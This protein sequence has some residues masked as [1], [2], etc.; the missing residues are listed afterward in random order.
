MYTT[1]DSLYDRCLEQTPEQLFI[2]SL[3]KEFELS[4]AE[5]KGV[6]ELAKSCL[7][8][9]VPQTIGKVK[10]LCA[11]RTAKHG[12]RLGEQD[13]IMVELTCLLHLQLT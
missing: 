8:G 13:L 7:F 5:S 4:P 6:L 9:E 1:R 12:K 3:R 11:S 2:N 10:F